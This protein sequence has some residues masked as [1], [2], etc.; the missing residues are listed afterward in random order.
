[1][2]T[3]PRTLLGLFIFS[4]CLLAPNVNAEKD[5]LGGDMGLPSSTQGQSLIDSSD[6]RSRQSTPNFSPAQAAE[7]V[8]SRMGGKVISVNTETTDSSVIYDVKLLNNGNMKIIQVDG[9]TGQLLNQ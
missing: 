3:A 2:L 1:M 9:N 8:R 5:L 6:I 7:R 4:A